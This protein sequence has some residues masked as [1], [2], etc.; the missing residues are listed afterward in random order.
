MWSFTVFAHIRVSS[1]NLQTK[2]LLQPFG[3]RSI[4]VIT[5]ALHP[6]HFFVLYKFVP[7][8]VVGRVSKFFRPQYLLKTSY[9][10]EGKISGKGLDI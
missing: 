6:Q 10:N 9:D 2:P 5:C 1:F 3:H 4:A 7:W 8:L